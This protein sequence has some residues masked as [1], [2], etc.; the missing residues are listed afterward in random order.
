M[1]GARQTNAKA[2]A[3]D[4]FINQGRRNPARMRLDT[5]VV[6][7]VNDAG[8]GSEGGL[9]APSGT[10]REIKAFGLWGEYGRKAGT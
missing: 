6:D 7:S 1:T 4:V 8:S 2:F 9:K 3:K 5:A 10:V